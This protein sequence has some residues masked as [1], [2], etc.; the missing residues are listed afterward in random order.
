MYYYPL[1]LLLHDCHAIGHVKVPSIQPSIHHLL[2]I[3]IRINSIVIINIEQPQP[4]HLQP[5]PI[6][7]FIAL[8]RASLPCLGIACRDPH[9]AVRQALPLK[10]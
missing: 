10:C 9:F 4:P 7:I 5:K 8:Y 2:Q 1:F 6:A 3:G